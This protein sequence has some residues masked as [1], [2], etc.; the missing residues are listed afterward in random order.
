MCVIWLVFKILRSQTDLW[1]V[2]DELVQSM[3]GPLHITGLKVSMANV[4]MPN[5]TKPSE[6]LGKP[7]CIRP[8]LVSD[9]YNT[10]SI[11]D[12]YNIRQVGSSYC[13]DGLSDS[14]WTKHFSPLLSVT[15]EICLICNICEQVKLPKSVIDFKCMVLPK[16][17]RQGEWVCLCVVG[18]LADLRTKESQD[19]FFRD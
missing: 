11:Q 7:W 6:I 15:G 9:L 2:L 16:E 17:G 10:R 4:L 12:L 18:A 13:M 14:E 8:V 5:T 1:D 19:G 3:K